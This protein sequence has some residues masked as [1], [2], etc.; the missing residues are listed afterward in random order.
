[1]TFHEFWINSSCS[2]LA[3]PKALREALRDLSETSWNA[4]LFS[5][6]K[7]LEKAFDEANTLNLLHGAARVRALSS[8]QP[9]K[10]S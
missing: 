9:L 10:D 3:L 8:I 7:E 2:T 6:E 5:A 1:M 4:A